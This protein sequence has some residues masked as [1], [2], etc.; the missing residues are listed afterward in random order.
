MIKRLGIAMTAMCCFNMVYA[1]NNQIVNNQNFHDI[2]DKGGFIAQEN[3][4]TNNTEFITPINTAENNMKEPNLQKTSD[5]DDRSGKFSGVNIGMPFT[6]YKDL[7][8]KVKDF[9]TGWLIGAKFGYRKFLSNNFGFNIYLDGNLMQNYFRHFL[10]NNNWSIE[11]YLSATANL[12]FFYNF[13][14]HFGIY[15]G[16]GIGGWLE[17]KTFYNKESH[18]KYIYGLYPQRRLNIGFQF[19]IDDNRTITF[20]ASFSNEMREIQTTYFPVTYMLGYTY[21]FGDDPYYSLKYLFR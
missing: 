13:N 20:G 15:L 6:L 1:I 16:L 19:N 7:N 9:G 10:P 3:T 2:K 4:T 5:F 17:Q 12:D 14:S 21:N 11:S 8:Y 18:N